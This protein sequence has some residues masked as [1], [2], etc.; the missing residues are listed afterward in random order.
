MNYFSLPQRSSSFSVT[1]LV[2]K[3]EPTCSLKRVA[4]ETQLGSCDGV[5]IVRKKLHM[6]NS[7]SSTPRKV[8]EEELELI[9]IERERMKLEANKLEIEKQKLEVPKQ[10]LAI[11]SESLKIKKQQFQIFSQY[12]SQGGTA[13]SIDMDIDNGLIFAQL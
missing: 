2:E 8:A 6:N 9:K 3:S 13:P 4:S 10:I 7:T 1:P 5:T 11:A 12:F